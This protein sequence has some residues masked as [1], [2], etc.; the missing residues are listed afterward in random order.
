MSRRINIVIEDDTWQ[1]LEE[2]PQGERS[3]TINVALREWARHR[4]RRDAA[5]EMD[6]LRSD[7]SAKP[8][9]TA[10]IARWVREDREGAH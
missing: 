8:V 5:A 9:T 7:A 2:V 4:R 6:L 1:F 3:R 10:E